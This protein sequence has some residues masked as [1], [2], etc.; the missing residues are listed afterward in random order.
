MQNKDKYV[1]TFGD[2]K[3]ELVNGVISVKYG[4]DNELLKAKD[5]KNI[6]KATEE[7]V[8]ACEVFGKAYKENLKRKTA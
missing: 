2:Y 6:N 3:L 8:E 4:K 1:K 7:F 5:V